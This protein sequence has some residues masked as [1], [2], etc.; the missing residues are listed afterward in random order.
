MRILIDTRYL[1][2][3]SADLDPTSPGLALAATF[4]RQGCHETHIWLPAGDLARARRAR[5]FWERLL[6]P[7]RLR[8]APA[9]A[10]GRDSWPARD[11]AS[12]LA[13]AALEE[14]RPD[15]VWVPGPEPGQGRMPAAEP[16]PPLDGVTWLATLPPIPLAGADGLALGPDW[17]KRYWQ[18]LKTASLIWVEDPAA[19]RALRDQLLLEPGRP[20]WFAS[21][22]TE[23]RAA[24][25]AAALPLTGAAHLAGPTALRP[26]QRPRPRPSLAYL[27]PLPPAATG[28]AAYSAELLPELARF[29]DITL[30]NAGP[31]VDDPW[32]IANFPVIEVAAFRAAAQDFDRVLYHLGNSPYHAHLLD[33]LASH[34]GVVVL[35]DFY[36]GHL[37]AWRDAQGG[38][39]GALAAAV[40]DAHGWAGLR[41]LAE[42]GPEACIW[43]YPASGG[44][45]AAARGLILHSRHAL[46]LA[47]QWLA[48]SLVARTRLIPHLRRLVTPPDRRLAR[49]GLGLGTE[50]FVVC[51]FGF[52]GPSKCSHELLAAWQASDL[53]AHPECRLVFV[54]QNAE[55]PYGAELADRLG[56]DGRTRITGY[57]APEDYRRWLA[58]ADLAVQLR[59]NSRGET[60]GTVLDCLAQGIP[61]ILSAH[62]GMTDIPTP[63]AWR[64]PEPLA[65]DALRTALETLYR[66][67]ARR[68]LLARRG[69]D[70]IAHRH[71]PRRI[72]EAYR[73]AL[74]DWAPVGAW[75]RRPLPAPRIGGRWYIDISTLRGADRVT[76]IERVTQELLFGL[77]EDPRVG[78][79]C[80]PVYATA[81]GYRQAW[82]AAL[83]RRGLTLANLE[84]E[85]VDPG[86]GDLFLGLDW[87]PGEIPRQRDLLAVWSARGTRIWFLVHDILPLTHPQWFPPEMAPFFGTWLA[88][89]AELADGCVCVSAT[90][91]VEL[92][93]YW[94]DQGL[95][96]PPRLAVSHNGAAPPEREADGD[97]P[98][99]STLAAALAARPS[100]LMVG[101]LEPRKGHA[102]ALA[103]LDCLWA[104]GLD[105]N[106]ILVGGAG[107]PHESAVNRRAIQALTERI[108]GHAEL[109]R[110]LFWPPDVSDGALALLYRRASALL[111]AAEHE[112]F[113][114]PLIEA[115]GHGL[116]LI[117]R[118]IPVFREIAGDHAWYFSAASGEDPEGERLAAEIRAWLKA[119]E[120]QMIPDSRALPPFTWA[121]SVARLRDLLLLDGGEAAGS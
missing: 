60:S 111:A 2:S 121:A 21:A 115:A 44:H 62:G 70:F 51:A 37:H 82:T 64:L 102:Q 16:P 85:P 24:E 30:V 33:L 89:L 84:D 96:A 47:R 77:L 95:A 72:A 75:G 35:H 63:C 100:L 97:P 1:P 5:R 59:R 48:P 108:T 110:R 81:A 61:L 42:A 117:V 50:D 98:L 104:Q 14:L 86:A 17:L 109:G 67:P 45:L 114:L 92:A 93:T 38:V 99:N 31:P 9:P 41:T 25:L 74:E 23:H 91:A 46:D 49:L 58:A 113:G 13:A 120:S 57:A 43:R 66:S 73:A 12:R 52:I 53:G 20:R 22:A 7:A 28:I 94:R 68:A 6:P 119:R 118:D 36:L 107:W 4:V 34:P 88:A 71:D 8:L 105:L 78:S 39:P 3:A 83:A 90:T 15:L 112:G 106:L 19:A 40:R 29:Y 103:A 27:S 54:G 76:G 26:V 11:L 116:P 101:T 79:R 56:A 10:A 32:L 69:R 55:G 18:W 87:S 65:M 80:I